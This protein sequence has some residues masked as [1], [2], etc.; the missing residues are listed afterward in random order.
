MCLIQN[1]KV[2]YEDFREW[3]RAHQDATAITRWLLQE[4]STV[5]LTNDSETPTFYQ[6][7]AGVTHCTYQRKTH[8]SSK[9]HLLKSF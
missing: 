2:T 6:T 9:L 5:S 3:L 7:L 1:E 4:R 8:V